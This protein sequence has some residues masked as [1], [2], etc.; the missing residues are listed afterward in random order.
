MKR[1]LTPIE[2]TEDTG[3]F[4][5][6]DE[7]DDDL[8]PGSSSK[9]SK[10]YEKVTPS[11]MM[12]NALLAVTSAGAKESQETIRASSVLGYVYVADVDDAKKKIR[13]LSPSSGR[14]PPNAIIMSSFPEDV[15]GLVS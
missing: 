12:Q 2:P 15:P 6:G 14:T 1:I 11:P 10:I 4:R 8:Y 5:A 13:L 9:E 7:Y 3:Q